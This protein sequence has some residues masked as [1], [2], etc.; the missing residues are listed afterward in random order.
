MKR[1]TFINISALSAAGT[2]TT[3]KLFGDPYSFGKI[4][5]IGIQR[6]LVIEHRCL[7]CDFKFHK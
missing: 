4:N 5:E 2:L 7:F 6:F 3:P 1:R